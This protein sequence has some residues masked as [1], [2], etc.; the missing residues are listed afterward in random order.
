MTYSFNKREI[1]RGY[2]R[3]EDLLCNL[4]YMLRVYLYLRSKCI[5]IDSVAFD[6][7][8]EDLTEANN[9]EIT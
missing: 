2:A 5:W 9:L 6:G 3:E 4:Y 7:T 8:L 1:F